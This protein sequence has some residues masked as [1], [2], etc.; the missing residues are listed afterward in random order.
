MNF[1]RST[2]NQ[3]HLRRKYQFG[4]EYDGEYYRGHRWSDDDSSRNR[5]RY[6][7]RDDDWTMVQC[8]GPPGSHWFTNH[9]FPRM[10]AVTGTRNPARRLTTILNSTV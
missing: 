5:D 3:E 6:Y 7:R 8:Q 10:A 1:M 4:R 2:K 9:V